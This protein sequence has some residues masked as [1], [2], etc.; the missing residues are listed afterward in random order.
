M[1]TTGLDARDDLSELERPF[2]GLSPVTGDLSRDRMLFEA[3]RAQ[4]AGGLSTSFLHA[5]LG[6]HAW[7]SL[8]SEC[9]HSPS[10][11]SVRLSKSRLPISNRDE[12][13]RRRA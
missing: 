8:V 10:D 4:R 3:G 11:P 5:R 13:R 7:S 2:K 12:R 1:D 6:R 9:F